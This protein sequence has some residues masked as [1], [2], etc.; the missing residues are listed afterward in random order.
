MAATLRL[1]IIR[2]KGP[3]ANTSKSKVVGRMRSLQHDV[4]G[5]AAVYPTQ[6]TSYRRTGKLGQTWASRGPFM[7]GQDLV[8]EVGNKMDYAGLVMGLKKGKR[9][10]V[11]LTKFRHL[12]WRS[13][14]DIGQEEIDKARPLILKALQGQ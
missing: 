1:E 14:E 4:V 2:P 13:L 3:I 5:S 9:G 8:V 6:R 10:S 7:Q 11:Q 12:G